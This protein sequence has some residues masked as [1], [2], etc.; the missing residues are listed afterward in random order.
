LQV[1]RLIAKVKH[2]TP[3]MAISLHLHDTRGLGLA[4]MMAGYEAGVEIFDVAAGGLGGCP[5]VVGAS[6][7]VPAEDAVNL[8]QQIG[9][10]TGIDLDALCRIVDRYEELL[11]RPLPGRMNRVVKFQK[12]CCS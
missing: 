2:A 12:E 6:G 9:V 7:N 11:G 4:N 3:G 1:R 5:F 10:D 8:F